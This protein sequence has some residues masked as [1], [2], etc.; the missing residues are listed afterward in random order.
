MPGTACAR[1]PGL[2]SSETAQSAS[3]R[4]A[5]AA[6]RDALDTILERYRAANPRVFGSV[7]R[8]VATAESDID[9]LVDPHARRRQ[10]ASSRRRHRR[11]A[12]RTPGNPRRP[13]G[14]IAAVGR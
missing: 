12:E 11:G 1:Y 2:M 7:A 4:A 3:L 6:H 8:G 10:R 9:L 5:I 13:G 14:R